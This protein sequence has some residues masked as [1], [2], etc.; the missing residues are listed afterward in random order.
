MNN[1]R[2]IRDDL[3][4]HPATDFDALDSNPPEE[5]DDRFPIHQNVLRRESARDLAGEIDRGPA[6]ALQIAAQFAF[7]QRS[8]TRHV[9]AAKI[10]LGGQMDLAVCSNRAAEARANFVIAQINVLAA[11]G[12]NRRVG[13][14][15]D[16]LRGLAIKALDDRAVMLGPKPFQL[17]KKRHIGHGLDGL[18]LRAKAHLH[19]RSQ[20][21]E[22][23]ATLTAHSALGRRIFHLLEATVRTI[24]TDFSRR[25]LGHG[26]DRERLLLKHGHRKPPWQAWPTRHS[27]QFP[28]SP[29]LYSWLRWS[30]RIC[31]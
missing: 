26:R 2:S 12:T 11:L 3:T 27:V 30:P 19:L 9:A 24:H 29:H 1:D 22:M 17:S 14:R 8:T 7:D 6:Q 18:V 16:F 23:R 5:L 20:G 31:R 15:T 13:G 21:H 25:R 28:V 10:P 4:C